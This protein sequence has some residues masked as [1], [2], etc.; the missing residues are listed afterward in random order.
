MGRTVLAD[1]EHPDRPRS[2]PLC[3]RRRRDGRRVAHRAGRRQDAPVRRHRVLHTGVVGRLGPPHFPPGTIP[4][5][6]GSTPRRRTPDPPVQPVQRAVDRA[7][8]ASPSSA[9]SRSPAPT[10][11]PH[12]AGEVSNFLFDN[13]FEG[14]DLDV[15]TPFGDLVLPE[16]DKPIFLAS[17]GIGCTPMIGMLDHLAESGDAR[18]ISIL[19]ADR[20]PA[21]HAHRRELETLVERIPSAD[22]HRWYEDLGARQPLETIAR[23]PG[24][25]LRSPTRPDHAGIPVRPV[26][27]HALAAPG[28][29]RTQRAR[30]EHPLRGVRSGQLEPCFLTTPASF[31]PTPLEPFH[32][33]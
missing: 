5:G 24:R 29:H 31:G 11:R 27:V 30:G 13:V 20:S 8:G 19:H 21:S 17:A 33:G 3:R 18:A 23:R 22:V 32:S 9:S 7:T 4:F 6:R 2:R 14:D 26:A 12:P 15:T 28:A 10:G 1:G 16:D 25:H